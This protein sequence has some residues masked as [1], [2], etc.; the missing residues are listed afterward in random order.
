MRDDF[1]DWL[2][3]FRRD[4]AAEALDTDP[5]DGL[6]PLPEVVGSDRA[7][8]EFTRTIRDYLDRA[9]SPERLREGR[10]QGQAKEA[11]LA[12]ISARYGVPAE[13]LL[14]I[15][16]LESNFGAMRGEL[17]VLSALATLACDGRRRALFEAEL[18]AAL[19]ILAAG[20]VAVEEM[21]GSWAGAMGHMQFMPSTYLAHAVDYDADGRRDIWS[22]DP[23]DAL[24]SAAAY[25]TA[26]G[27]Q[28]DQGWAVE[29]CLPPGF[30]VGLTGR[31]TV[32]PLS[33]WSELGL[34]GMVG[35]AHAGTGLASV[36][37]PAGH[38][39]PAFLTFENFAVLRRYNAADSYVLAVGL[40][41]DGIAGRPG[42][43]ARWPA[44]LT[45]LSHEEMRQ[46]QAA[47]TKAGFDTL[48]AD[49]IAGTNTV[50]AVR[51]FQRSRGLP[52]DGHP[53]ATL[54]ALL[55]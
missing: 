25:L 18:R 55:R 44:G 47:L 1:K 22:D 50:R 14:A 20:D 41:A 9:V 8:A 26:E 39:G 28:T 15:W 54:L 17:P 4:A 12:D 52:P 48:G 53:S 24:A 30:D 21:L 2:A 34:R 19:R 6:E 5:L 16:G 33:D 51:A 36:L 13:I 29:T 27:W 42:L 46:L 35:A 7:Q 40:L 43:Q 3:G 23:A 38:R 31:E 32:L 11:L 37:L 45:A 10:R 49:G